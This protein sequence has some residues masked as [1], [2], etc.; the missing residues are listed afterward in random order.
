[1]NK[2]EQ[3]LTLHGL[4]LSKMQVYLSLSAGRRKQPP[5]Q[6]EA[7]P[8][9]IVHISAEFAPIAKVG[10]LADVVTGV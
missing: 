8:L 4:S 5:A 3:G 6:K 10:G 7:S 9:H 2:E 1:M